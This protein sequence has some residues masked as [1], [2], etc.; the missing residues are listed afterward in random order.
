MR[1]GKG[2]RKGGSIES[3]IDKI[4]KGRRNRVLVSLVENRCYSIGSWTFKPLHLEN[5]FSDFFGG[6]SGGEVLMF[7]VIYPKLA[8]R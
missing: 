2:D 6:D 4:N 1:P 3:E 7:M 5:S 8:R